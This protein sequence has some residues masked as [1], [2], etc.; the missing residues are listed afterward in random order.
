LY[1]FSSLTSVDSTTRINTT[2]S[3]TAIG[4]SDEFMPVELNDED[5]DYN[6]GIELMMT[7]V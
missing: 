7:T 5:D 3:Y 1:F 4:T 2:Y 6:S